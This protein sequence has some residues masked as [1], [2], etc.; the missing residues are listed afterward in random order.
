MSRGEREQVRAHDQIG[1]R[2]WYGDLDGPGAVHVENASKGQKP[3][4]PP[5]HRQQ[6]TA[7]P[8]GDRSPR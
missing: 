3:E 4:F 6:P 5:T 8:L 7:G 1:N 2:E